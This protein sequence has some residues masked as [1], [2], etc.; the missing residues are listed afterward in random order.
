VADKGL[1]LT[2]FD[3]VFGYMGLA[4]WRRGTLEF[5]LKI[6]KEFEVEANLQP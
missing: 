6:T 5:L 2:S 4:R 3:D 1:V